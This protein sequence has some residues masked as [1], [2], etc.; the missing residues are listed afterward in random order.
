MSENQNRND[1]SQYDSM[2]TEELEEI[3]RL[4]AEAPQ[5]Q[6]ADGELIFY[7]MEVLAKREKENSTGKKG[8]TNTG[9]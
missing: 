4:D 2:T 8:R 5:G 9:K 3:L 7:V 6:A 1:Y